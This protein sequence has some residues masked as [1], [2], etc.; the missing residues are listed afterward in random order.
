MLCMT[1]KEGANNFISKHKCET[2]KVQY[3]LVINETFAC[4]YESPCTSEKCAGDGA[5]IGYL[6]AER[7]E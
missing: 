1:N 6:Q 4:F 2:R 5:H 3:S 7:N